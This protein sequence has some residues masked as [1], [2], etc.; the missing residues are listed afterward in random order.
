MQRTTTAPDDYFASLPADRAEE[1]RALDAAIA[2]IFAGQERELW[3]GIF[4]GGTHQRILGYGV[5]QY[6]GRSGAKGEWFV[7]GI[8]VQKDHLT[9]YVTGTEDG[10]SLIKRHGPRLGKAKLGSGS[11]T[12][13]RLADVDLR[14]VAEMATRAR[15]LMSGG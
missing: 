3:E 12:F 8:A 6:E 13:R 4:Y 7:V 9:L 5:Y 1:M 2:P 10:E 14:V 11:V 15:D